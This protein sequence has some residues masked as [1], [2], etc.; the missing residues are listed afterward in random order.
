[1]LSLLMLHIV[2]KLDGVKL[3]NHP[4]NKMVQWC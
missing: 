1:M 4:R 2:M 3:G